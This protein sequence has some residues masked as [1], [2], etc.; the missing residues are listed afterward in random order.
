MTE[1]VPIVT[2]TCSYS[3]YNFN[4]KISVLEYTKLLLI[5]YYFLPH[6]L[7]FCYCTTGFVSETEYSE[8]ER[9]CEI[10]ALQ[11]KLQSAPLSFLLRS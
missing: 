1:N 10:F 3:V 8:N 7:T 11:V 2:V 6:T 5:I 4:N 9:K